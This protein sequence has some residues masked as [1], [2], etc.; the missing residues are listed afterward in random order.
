MLGAQRG[1]VVCY[2]C[3]SPL[4]VSINARW[5]SNARRK[6]HVRA[7][8][9][10]AAGACCTMSR[11]LRALHERSCVSPSRSHGCQAL[12]S[13][14]RTKLCELATIAVMRRASA[15]HW[16]SGSVVP[17]RQHRAAA[18]GAT[19]AGP[20]AGVTAATAGPA[21]AAHPA[22][23]QRATR[24]SD[25][26][27]SDDQLRGVHLPPAVAGAAVG[28]PAARARVEERAER[29]A[30][31]AQHRG[32]PAQVLP[33]MHGAARQMWRF[34]RYLSSLAQSCSSATHGC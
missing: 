15:L 33:I 13:S 25:S 5:P 20:H 23:M 26:Q 19:S 16:R 24:H 4:L 7:C 8:A 14:C 12:V 22:G 1:T 32:V 10:L 28:Q 34:A 29:H 21:P 30:R 31:S 6:Q 18:A 3:R 11:A 2:A 17:A 9:S 27:R